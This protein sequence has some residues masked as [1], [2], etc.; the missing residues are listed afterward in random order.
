[1]SDSALME[2]LRDT[3]KKF[4]TLFDNPSDV[5]W[6][7]DLQDQRFIYVSDEIKNI[8]GYLPQEA[9]QLS[10]AQICTPR[11]MKA[12][13]AILQDEITKLERG[14]HKTLRLRT[15]FITKDNHTVEADV[16]W[17]LHQE[18][19]RVRAIGIL[20]DPYQRKNAQ[21]IEEDLDTQLQEVIQERDRLRWEMKIL[22]GLLP[23]SAACKKIRDS[24]GDW[25]TLEE[26]VQ[27]QS[28]SEFTHTICP[29]CKK[30][31]YPDIEFND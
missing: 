21:K 13:M 23:I 26:Y 31:L 17:R 25:H 6:V 28:E 9:R 24:N 19:G 15:E 2:K 30:Q 10:P 8:L 18:K 7:L 22:Q 3:E 12:A 11:C 1:M 16:D 29:P 5:I 4:R 27:S 14:E 20:R